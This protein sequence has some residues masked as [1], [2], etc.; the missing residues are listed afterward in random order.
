MKSFYADRKVAIAGGAGFVGTNLIVRLLE[1]G[2][3]VR[4]SIHKKPPQVEDSRIKY[5]ECE[6]TEKKDCLKLVE[7]VDM[8][9][10]HLVMLQSQIV[11]F[12]QSQKLPYLIGFGVSVDFLKIHQF[13][14]IGM[15][16]DMVT[17][18]GPG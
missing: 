16:E 10:L 11:F 14:D 18:V 4:A 6:L 8:V 12:D 5:V 2:A 1:L 17:T 9:V 13:R 15:D 3:A 7:D